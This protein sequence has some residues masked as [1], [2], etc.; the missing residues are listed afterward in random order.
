MTLYVLLSGPDDKRELGQSHV[1]SACQ[2]DKGMSEMQVEATIREAFEDKIP[3][4]VDLEVLVCTERGSVGR[5]ENGT[6]GKT[7][8]PLTRSPLALFSAWPMLPALGTRSQEGKGG[9]ARSLCTAA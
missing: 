6:R 3:P 5:A 2:F 9:T 7:G 8:L 1:I 4:L